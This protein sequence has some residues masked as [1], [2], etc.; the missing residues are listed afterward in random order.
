[1]TFIITRVPGSR[2]ERKD[3]PYSSKHE[4]TLVS[5]DSPFSSLRLN[6]LTALFRDRILDNSGVR[7][8]DD[9]SS[10]GKE[11]FFENWSIENVRSCFSLSTLLSKNF[12]T[13]QTMTG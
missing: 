11:N 8:S 9:F 12:F 6:A 5:S 3:S 1:M 10:D 13:S 7:P 2:G 4:C